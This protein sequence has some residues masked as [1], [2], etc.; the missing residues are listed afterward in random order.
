MKY[1]KYNNVMLTGAC[2]A[3]IIFSSSCKKFEDVGSPATELTADKVYADSTSILAASLDLYGDY[4]VNSIQGLIVYTNEYGSTSADDA[5]YPGNNVDFMTNQLSGS[6]N[7]T[8]PLYYAFYTMML[9]D[10]SI[11][12][13][14]SHT[15][16]ISKGLI[17]QLT[18][19]AKFW[20]A[21]MYFYLVSYYGDVPLVLNTNALA[22]ASLPRTPKA[23]V[24]QQIIQDLLD[25]KS[26]LTDAY[27][28]G[29]NIRVNKEAVSAF[30]ARVY[31]FEATP[32]YSASETEATNVL[33]SGLYSL[34]SLSNVF[35]NTSTE[36]IWQVES[37]HYSYTGVTNTGSAFLPVGNSARYVLYQ[38]LSNTFEPGD[39]R[40]TN[41]TQPITYNGIAYYYPYKYKLKNTSQSG[42]EY[43]VML[44][45]GEVYLN[46]AEARADQNNIPG[47]Q[48]DLN[49][50]RKRAGLANTTASDQASLLTAIEHERWVE[51]FT[52]NSDR[53]FTLRRTGTIGTI[54]PVT[55]SPDI[56]NYS[57]SAY[58]ALYPIPDLQIRANPNL[59][60]NPGY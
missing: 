35:I 2:L 49:V 43:S 56:P 9:N 53:W 7:S 46:R 28:D 19:E 47:A 26:L 44:R 25:A 48:A 5:F 55:K 39:Q 4:N 27:P 24:Y 14:L 51:L 17:N 8:V 42:N 21:Y 16:A 3:L 12:Q 52:E 41:W 58:Q 31:L 54:L 29:S 32:N 57:W 1:L 45:L 20:R 15:T 36:T 50:I 11:L 38:S 33:N 22:N 60:Q 10:N 23:Q 13:G 18:G 6:S 59:T 40:K 30:L 34:D 37:D